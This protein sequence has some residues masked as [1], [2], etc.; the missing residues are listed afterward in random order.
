MVERKISQDDPASLYVWL[1]NECDYGFTPGFTVEIPE[2]NA[3][4]T[5][6]VYDGS[7]S[8]AHA[9]AT[10]WMDVQD[11]TADIWNWVPAEVDW[12]SQPHR[13]YVEVT[14]DLEHPDYRGDGD[15]ISIVE[16]DDESIYG[17]PII[18]TGE[19]GSNETTSETGGEG[20]TGGSGGEEPQGN[21]GGDIGSMIQSFIDQILA[22]IRSLFG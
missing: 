13:I 21:N 19:E 6:T 14:D 3:V 2:I 8:G 1:T 4:P 17:G 15:L 7:P 16:T 22:L 5:V 11:Q 20:T 10:E 18:I 9:R 12:T